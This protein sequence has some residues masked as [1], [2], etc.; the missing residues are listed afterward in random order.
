LTQTIEKLQEED[1][2]LEIAGLFPR[3]GEWTEENY[4]SLPE[5]NR[6]IELSEGRLVISPSPTDQHQKIVVKLNF[7]IYIYLLG[8]NLGE[9]RCA[10]MDVWL[11]KNTVRQPD[12][13]FMSN[14]HKD[15]ITKNLW[16]IPDLVMEILSENSIEEDRV[17]K[18]KQYQKA[19]ISEYWIIDP[20]LRTIEVFILENGAYILF[21]KFGA[22]D[23]AHSKLLAGFQVAVISV[24]E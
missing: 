24:F 4:F 5:T 12:I 7:Y 2:V 18:F 14:E 10:P 20:F 3:Q 19:G 9:F 11:Y 17:C 21:G 15:R 1:R 6:I 23:T 16:N 13:V 8:K 22:G